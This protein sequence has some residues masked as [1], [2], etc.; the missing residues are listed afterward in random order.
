MN[1]EVRRINGTEAVSLAWRYIT[2]DDAALETIRLASDKSDPAV[3]VFLGTK[4]LAL[5][6]FI[7]LGLISST[8]FVWMEHTPDAAAHK[9]AIVRTGKQVL[10]VARTRYPRVIGNCSLGPRSE[11][12][13]KT[14]GARFIETD[15]ITKHF[16]I[17]G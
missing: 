11:A 13:L 16:V 17:E 14:L 15:T 2:K 10:A 5:G 7:P 9:H 4:L 6:G 3:S 8:A 12:W 1:T